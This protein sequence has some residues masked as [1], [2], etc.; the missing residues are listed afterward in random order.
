LD[1]APALKDMLIVNK[2]GE[3]GG[4]VRVRKGEGEYAIVG[5]SEV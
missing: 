2:L 3:R 4:E 5:A 1:V